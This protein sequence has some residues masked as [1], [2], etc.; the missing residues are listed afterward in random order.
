VT[1][2]SRATAAALQGVPATGRRR[3]LAV[4]RLRA[5]PHLDATAVDRFLARH[6]VPIVEGATCTF[7]FRGEADEVRVR[8]RVL[9][10]P[11]IRL[12]RLAGTD[13]W[14]AAVEL[15]EGSR[16]EYQLETRLGE[17]WERFNDPLNPRLARSPVGSSSVCHARGYVV[18]DWT[19]E[20]ADARPGELVAVSVPSQALRRQVHARLYLPARFRRTARYR[21]LVVHDGSDYLE[22]SSMKTVLDNLVHRLDVAETC[23]VFLDPGDRLREY[24]NSSAHARFLHA[25]L[26]PWLESELPLL[27][28]PSSRCLM[29]A[30]FGAVAA[31]SAAVR[32]PHTFGAL[33]L[34]SGSFVFTDIG[35]DHGGG[36]AFDPVVRFV[37]R[38]RARPR[39]VA[40]R[41]FLSCGIYEPLI[42]PNRSMATVLRQTGVDVHYLEMR[43]GHNWENW[44]NQLRDAL[45]WVFPGPQKFV[46][47]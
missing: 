42:T 44:R 35:T 2:T 28:G 5:H 6:E 33:L 7:L 15:P 45:S 31:L 12:R 37:N 38:F 11:D 24:A 26:L 43:D 9:G 16:V 25:E 19:R 10:L 40:D 29:G 1:V 8:H 3:K 20:D 22:Y 23:V 46:Y 27:P 47:E 30:S 39:R 36:P 13:L 17:H 4:N 21:L 34:Q 18:P 41:V 32:V 14:Y